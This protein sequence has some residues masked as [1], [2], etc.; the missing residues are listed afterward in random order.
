MNGSFELPTGVGYTSLL[1]GNTTISG[2]MTILNGV[3]W[4]NATGYGGAA[5]GVMAVD[6][7]NYLYTG[8][9]IQQTFATQIG[10][11]YRLNFS[12]GTSQFAGRDGTAHIDVS[13][14]LS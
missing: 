2:W 11:T 12:L 6:L 14:C 1:G 7:A 10:H 5:D 3:E 8:C 9:G 4:F 13:V